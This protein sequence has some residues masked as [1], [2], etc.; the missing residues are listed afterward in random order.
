MART[1]KMTYEQIKAE[2][3]NF[4][5]TSRT[6]YGDYGYAAGFFESL[7]A[8]LLAELPARRQEMETTL[9]RRTAGSM[10]AR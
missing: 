2:L 10:K 7:C 4:A 9:I 1:R 8:S 5:E 3:K 6:A